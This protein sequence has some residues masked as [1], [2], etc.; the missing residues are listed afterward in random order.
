MSISIA[1][2]G[3]GGSDPKSVVD[4]IS[5]DSY[6]E[7][8]VA[9]AGLYIVV[10]GAPATGNPGYGPV[11][12][13]TSYRLHISVDQP[14]VEVPAPAALPLFGIGLLGLVA[15]RGRQRTV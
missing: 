5:E 6:I 4:P 3:A 11:P 12:D 10:V 14:V 8:T 7:T 13:A 9:N 15:L 1:T 2:A